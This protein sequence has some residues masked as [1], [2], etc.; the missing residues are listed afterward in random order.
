MVVI[1]TGSPGTG[2]TFTAVKEM[3]KLLRRGKRVLTNVPLKLPDE[4][5]WCDL[6]VWD[7]DQVSIQNLEDF[8]DTHHEKD[9]DGDMLYESQTMVVIDEAHLFLGDDFL[10]KADKKD[11]TLFISQH[12]KWAFDFIIITQEI[13]QITRPVRKN[14]EL[15]CMHFKME[16]FPIKSTVINLLI[17]IL[18]LMKKPLFAQIEQVIRMR[19]NEFRGKKFFFFN[20][21]IGKMYNTHKRYKA[22]SKDR[23]PKETARNQRE[24][25]VEQPRGYGVAGPIAPEVA[26]LA[27]SPLADDVLNPYDS[28][29]YTLTQW[30]IVPKSED[31]SGG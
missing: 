13:A 16:H 7:N 29:R 10:E 4:L 1:Y 17:V 23:K 3:L 20:K 27:I 26:E 25:P 24:Q 21:K 19:N 9:E 14:F 15:E 18:K 30:G 31:R 11:W 2:K 5:S 6:T 28:D 12:R 22:K 8:A